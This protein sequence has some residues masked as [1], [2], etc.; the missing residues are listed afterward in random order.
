MSQETTTPPS[1][2]RACVDTSPRCSDAR[3]TLRERVDPVK[4]QYIA[5]NFTEL[6][7]GGNDKT[8]EKIE[9]MRRL[10]MAYLTRCDEDGYVTVSYQ[11]ARGQH[12]G[13][14]YV[15]GG[16]LQ[17]MRGTIR[18]TISHQFYHD[19]DIANAHPVLIAHY[20]TQKGIP[21]PRLARYVNNRE[22]ELTALAPVMTRDDAKVTYLKLINGGKLKH[23]L[24]LS[25]NLMGFRDEMISIQK[26]C[27]KLNPEFTAAARKSKP[28]NVGG[29]TVNRVMCDIENRVLMFMRDYL[30]SQEFCPEVLVFDGL[31]IPRSPELT[32]GR[33]ISILR[34]C[35]KHVAQNLGIHVNLLEKPMTT[36]ML[37]LPPRDSM[38]AFRVT[39]MQQR[40]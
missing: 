17:S 36:K 27:M 19:F 2:K 25:P 31:M 37:Q 15:Q 13:R 30:V 22:A 18:N 1:H 7:A 24:A 23:D 14:L 8:P 20:L 38:P 10:C 39:N 11:Y 26:V 4:L 21:H 34:G 33:I 40:V 3:I 35:E 5:D 29:S 16:G 32:N 6:G 9:K 28:H 12:S